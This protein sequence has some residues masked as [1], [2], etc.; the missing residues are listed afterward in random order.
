MKIKILIILILVAY[1][2]G[3]KQNSVKRHVPN[4][5]E[6]S[7]FESKMT[8]LSKDL[9]IP[10]LS[11]ALINE[12]RVIQ[13]KGIGYTDKEKKVKADEN[14]VFKIGSMADL[15]VATLVLQMAE[16]EKLE[17]KK[18]VSDY[19]IG[20]NKTKDA[21][22]R[23]ILSHTSQDK[24]GSRFVFDPERFNL[25]GEL[26]K[27]ASGKDFAS[28][29]KKK[30]TR[31]L[32]MNQTQAENNAGISE[33]CVS[34]VADLAKYS[35]AMDRKKLFENGNT[36]ELMFRPV[37]LTDGE[38]T[39]SGLGC[40]VQF[41]NNKKYIWAFGQ[42]KDV[43][44]L[45]L[46]SVTDSLTLIVL[47]NSGNLNAPFQLQKGDVFASPVATQFLK[48]FILQRDSLPAIDMN[49]P[50]A[51]L[52]ENLGK[53]SRTV[54]RDLLV[55]EFVSYIRMYKYLNQPEKVARLAGIYQE[56]L[57]LDVPWNLLER[58]PRTAIS[59]VGDYV[60]LKRPFHI[61]KDTI[62]DVFAVGEFTKEVGQ[63]LWQYDIAEIYFDMK[64]EKK[65]LFNNRSNR[66]YRFDYDYSEVSGNY[67]TA[68]NIKFAQGDPSKTS[69][70]FEIEIPWKT[71][72]SL[73]PSDGMKMGF[74]I[75]VADNDGNG[76]KNFI[77][78]HFKNDQEAWNSSAVYGTMQL[79]KQA[80]KNTDDSQCFS[81]KVHQPITIDGKIE[82]EWNSAPRY[83]LTHT[84]QGFDKL[85][86]SKDLSAWFRSMWDDDF[87]YMLVEVSDDYKY[88]FPNTADY[89]W[90]EN[91][92]HDTVWIM[93]LQDTQYAGGISTNRYVNKTL[94]LK[95][96]NYTLNYSSNQSNS[97]NHW[98][99]LRP[100]ISFYGI[101]VY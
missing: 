96:G 22:I 66:Q 25:L 60:K 18:Y 97:F 50:D 101:A 3:P 33:S 84:I 75:N 82:S 24:P 29:L 93:Q 92:K 4:E 31:K 73:K 2:C 41:Y 59:E 52:K 69:Y 17:I 74:D 72:D 44:A 21:E 85:Q 86:D 27:T 10:G 76:R 78:W 37:Y 14:S 56:V 57:R 47:A 8:G 1:G 16:K 63:D 68:D 77:T 98:T 13:A 83:Q 19:G 20:D 87:L 53:A 55:H 42:D 12:S 26:L 51:I 67:S 91:E 88:R 94:L 23:H 40:F 36:Y 49:E 90:I 71:L 35:M 64:N 62:V 38:L 5:K 39:P 15:F 48:T 79:C 81:P 80:R 70:L 100:E 89:G 34:S 43:S 54:H 28:L 45:M 9:N 32:G 7:A 30:I 99:R 95:K 65:T 46:K 61:E 58:E 6:L 11:Y